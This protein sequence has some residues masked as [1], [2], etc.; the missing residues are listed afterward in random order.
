MIELFTIKEKGYHPFLVREG[1]QLAQLNYTDEQHID[2][3][4]ILDVHLKTD[5]IFVPIA[6]NSILIA[7]KIEL[8]EPIFEI[9]FLQH[10]KIYNIPQ[11]VWHNIAMEPGGEVL[12]AEKANTHIS[13]FEFFPLSRR[14]QKELKM[15]V[16]QLFNSRKEKHTLQKFRKL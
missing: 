10:N 11:D 7:A 15:M 4:T 14:K 6:G 9:E 12:I 5:E 16:T 13:D 8:G 3:I 2:S 1:W